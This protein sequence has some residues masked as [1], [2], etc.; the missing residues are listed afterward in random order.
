LVDTNA[1]VDT[2]T[3]KCIAG[4]ALDVVEDDLPGAMK[5]SSFKNVIITPH[6]AYYSVASSKKMKINSA[7]EVA[8]FLKGEPP[9]NPMA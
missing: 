1:L 2:L 3:Q 6:T 7:E 9:K 5:F 4:A 8:R